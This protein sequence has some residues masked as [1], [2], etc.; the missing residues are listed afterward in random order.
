[1]EDNEN[2]EY[3][4]GLEDDAAMEKLWNCLCCAGEDHTVRQ[5]G[6]HLNLVSLKK[7]AR[8]PYLAEVN[9]LIPESRKYPLATALLCDRCAEEGKPVL[10]A[11][12][13][14][15]GE[16]GHAHYWRVPVTEL[17]DPEFYWPDHHPYRLVQ[18]RN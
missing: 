15:M 9:I 7:L 4:G 3:E 10:Y 13:G 5:G 12:A 16:D 8:W 18:G 17:A 1:M 11:I 2:P 6:S 14:D